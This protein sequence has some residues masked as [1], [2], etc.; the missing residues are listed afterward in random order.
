MQAAVGY[1]RFLRRC[2]DPAHAGRRLLPLTASHFHRDGR[3]PLGWSLKCKACRYRNDTRWRPLGTVA[4]ERPPEPLDPIHAEALRRLQLQTQA[5]REGAPPPTFEPLKTMLAIVTPPPRRFCPI[6]EDLFA[7][8]RCPDCS[9][10]VHEARVHE[11]NPGIVFLEIE[12]GINGRRAHYRGHV[13]FEA[14]VVPGSKVTHEPIAATV[15][16]QIAS[17]WISVGR[18]ETREAFADLCG[19]IRAAAQKGRL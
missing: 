8:K 10:V 13:E 4:N 15:E 16:K 12:H 17:S 5:A 3:S 18:P 9:A 19:R 14:F 2:T 7:G 1:P 11:D 6:C